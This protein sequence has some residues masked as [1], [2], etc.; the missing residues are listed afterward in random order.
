[1]KK[2]QEFLA[3]NPQLQIEIQGHTDNQGSKTYNLEL[4]TQRA[5]NVYEALLRFGIN[6]RQLTYKGYGDSK[7]IA[8]NETEE[9]R[10][11]NRR[12]QFKVVKTD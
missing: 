4:S 6:T 2:L 7:P 10:R 11:I 12:T 3:L 9:G 1:M 8:S 5:Q